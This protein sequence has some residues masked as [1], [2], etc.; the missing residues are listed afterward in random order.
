MILKETAI[1]QQLKEVDLSYPAE[2]TPYIDDCGCQIKI[3]YGPEFNPT[4][5]TAE[6]WV[7]YK[8]GAGY[9]S[10]LTSVSGSA[11]QGRRGYV[12]C[13]T[14]NGQWQF[15]MGSGQSRSPWLVVTGPK[16]KPGVWTHLA[17]TYDQVSQIMTLYVNGQAVGQRTGVP[18]LPNT[19][20]PLHIGAGAIE[21]AGASH[22]LFRGTITKVRVWSRALV[23][24]ELQALASTGE[25]DDAAIVSCDGQ[26][27]YIEIPYSPA[28]NPTQFTVSCWANVQGEQGRWR[29]IVTSRDISPEKGY[30]LYAGENNRWQFWLGTGP[31]GWV[32]INGPELKLNTWTFLAATYDGTIAKFYVN[33]ELAIERVVNGFVPNT[34]RPFRI[35][36]GVTEGNPS[37]FFP[38]HIT[39]VRVWNRACVQKEIQTEMNYRLDGD[40]AGLVGYW[41]LNEGTGTAVRDKSVY[42]NHGTMSSYVEIP[43]VP[44]L[45]LTQFTLSCW[46]N[47]QD[48][49]GT[50]RAA[51]SSQDDFLP[52]GYVLYAGQD[53][54]WQFCLGAGEAGWTVVSGTE[55]IFHSRT[56]LVATYDGA[57]LKFYINGELVG[58]KLTHYVPNTSR[59]L[60]IGA[61]TKDGKPA[62]FFPGQITDVRIWNRACSQAEIKNEM[63]SLAVGDAPGLMG[64]WPLKEATDTTVIDR[65]YNSYHGVIKRADWENLVGLV[66]V[67]GN[68][69]GNGNGNGKNGHY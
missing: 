54:K 31:N 34:A 32:Y 59:P 22:C 40:E 58:E 29:S 39:E 57:M 10:I 33:G 51:I 53:N 52:K 55:A 2:A 16:A 30:I 56:Y 24:Q 27:D 65:T 12:F 9:R 60:R 21:Q 46:V 15:W 45:N 69:N 67:R 18:F 66:L 37:Y 19:C 43:Y 50:W 13:V 44:A 36:A 68:L 26:G 48:W 61:G 1:A 63:N 47:L 23:T 17:G 14:P 4:S 25:P 20:N 3:P 28:L 42:H 41:P 49:Q 7:Q 6:M 64:F 35:A 11:W 8:G 62:N 5:F 38:G